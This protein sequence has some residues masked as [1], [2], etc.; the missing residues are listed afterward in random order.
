MNK[1]S[2]N[3]LYL[4]LHFLNSSIFFKYLISDLKNITSKT[5]KKSQDNGII[6]NFDA[7]YLIQCKK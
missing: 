2:L 4:K 7:D 1:I 6:A 3:F 5:D